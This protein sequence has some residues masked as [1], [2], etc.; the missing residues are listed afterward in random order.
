M[1]KLLGIRD[2]YMKT[3]MDSNYKKHEIFYT[4]E[5]VGDTIIYY[6]NDANIFGCES[7]PISCNGC[8]PSLP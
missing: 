5:Q 8:V 1:E 2:V 3:I 4:R 7:S 6:F